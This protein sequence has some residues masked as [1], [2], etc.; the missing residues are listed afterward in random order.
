MVEAEGVL[1]EKEAARGLPDDMRGTVTKG[2]TMIKL[3][4]TLFITMS[5]SISQGKLP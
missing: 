3:I 1:A 4:K 2:A 5:R